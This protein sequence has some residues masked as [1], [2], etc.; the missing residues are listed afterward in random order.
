MKTDSSPSPK[1]H[2]Q[3]NVHSEINFCRDVKILLHKY[4]II[5]LYY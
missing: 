4:D 2:L 1:K 3:F 5:D